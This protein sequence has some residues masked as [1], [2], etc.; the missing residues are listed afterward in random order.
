M[1]ISAACRYYGISRQA[2]YKQIHVEQAQI[3]REVVVVGLVQEKRLR[4]PRIGTRKLHYLLKGAF[5]ERCI[6]LG[7]DGL[8]DVLRSA[9]LLVQP[10][11][12]YHKTTDSHHRFHKHPNARG[13]ILPNARGHI[14]YF[15]VTSQ[16]FYTARTFR[17]P[18]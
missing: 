7:R 14:L 1:T 10:K 11:R 16:K 5:R 6:K 3:E 12:A 13:H 17:Q 2:Y 15:D 4:Q 8:F 18:D 9:R